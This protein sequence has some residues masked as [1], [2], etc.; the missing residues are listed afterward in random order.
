M[1]DIAPKEPK[2]LFQPYRVLEELSDDVIA[3]PRCVGLK[4]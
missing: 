2:V 1:H 3:N 4:L